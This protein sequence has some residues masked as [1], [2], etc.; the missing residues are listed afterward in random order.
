MAGPA[1]GC[2]LSMVL[3]SPSLLDCLSDDEPENKL[4]DHEPFLQNRHDWEATLL[5]DIEQLLNTKRASREVPEEY[6]NCANS[7]LEYGVPDC[8][9][10]GVKNPAAQNELRAAIQATLLRFEPRLTSVTV[11]VEAPSDL[12]PILR[13]KVDA[14]LRLEPK[15]EPIRFETLLQ[16]DRSR[17]VVRKVGR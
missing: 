2:P 3:Y 8:T 7:L 6:R 5:A 16:T 10:I 12:E 4:R 9:G 15:P 1:L 14:M 11:T 17:L 13:F